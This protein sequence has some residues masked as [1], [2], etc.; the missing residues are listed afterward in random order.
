MDVQRFDSLVRSIYE[1]VLAPDGWHSLL[2]KL[3]KELGCEQSAYLVHDRNSQHTFITELA[4]LDLDF[5]RQYETRFEALDPVR[6][7][8]DTTPEGEWFID[9]RDLSASTRRHSAFY[10]DFL[11]PYGLGAIVC[12]PLINDG[13]T[14]AG[15]AFQSHLRDHEPGALKARRL[16]PLVPHLRCG[17]RLRT[18]FSELARHANLGKRMLDRFTMPLMVIDA[19][20]RVLIGN[21]AAEQWLSAEGRLFSRVC[22]AGSGINRLQLEH[23]AKTICAN[24]GPAM[25]AALHLDG[26]GIAAVLVG[27]PLAQAHALAGAFHEPVG[28]LAVLRPQQAQRATLGLLRELYC[29]SKAEVRLVL[30][31]SAGGSLVDAASI[32]NLSPE[33]A[34]TQ[35]KSVFRKTGCAS[36]TALTRLVTSLDAIA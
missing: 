22:A 9:E 16:R 33:T 28:M 31:W 10:Q 1:G 36:Q 3:R 18:R 8:V 30:A 5:V 11:R 35:I 24:G 17:A 34:R 6:P 12:T 4:Q 25:P 19:R 20:A 14:L 15:I 29:L 23:L 2:A 7:V 21:A 32:L 27:L 13:S 26:A